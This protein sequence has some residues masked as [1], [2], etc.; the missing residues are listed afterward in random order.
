MTVCMDELAEERVKILHELRLIGSGRHQRFA[1]YGELMGLCLGT[2]LNYVTLIDRDYQHYLSNAG[3]PAKG[4]WL[5]DSGCQYLFPQDGM[6]EVVDGRHDPRM[7][8]VAEANGL[9][10]VAYYAGVGIKVNE[11]VVGTICSVDLQP[12]AAMTEVQHRQLELIG[13]MVTRDLEVTY[14]INTGLGEIANTL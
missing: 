2:P 9:P 7:E 6:L 4:T 11:C 13:E 12:R 14:R 3:E 5:D 8:K 10:C 1:R